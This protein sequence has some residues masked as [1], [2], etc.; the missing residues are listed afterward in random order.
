[1]DGPVR[2]EMA[3]CRGTRGQL[4]RAALG[5]G[6][7]AAS[8]GALGARTLRSAAAAGPS[9][10]QDAR[11]LNVLLLLEQVQDAFYPEALS[12]AQLGGEL[13]DFARVVGGQERA[14]VAFLAHRL[15]SRA[16]RPPRSDFG[17][18][19][20]SAERFRRAAIDL[21][22]AAIA[23]YIGQGA[24][25]TRAVTAAVAPL[26]SVEARQVAWVRDLAGENPAPRPA[27]PARTAGAV[28]DELHSKGFIA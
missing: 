26:V 9:P 4:L 8:A 7:A 23:A 25:L 11:I 24:N 17:D 27:D 1:M 12:R 14:H 18:A 20:G 16:R 5:G 21:E 28:V 15:G 22:E 10:E 3:G 6:A 2:G 13:R 19:L